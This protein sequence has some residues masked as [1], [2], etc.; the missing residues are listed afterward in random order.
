MRYW[1]LR[2]TYNRCMDLYRARKRSRSI[3][4]DLETLPSESAEVAARG[5]SLEQELL[6]NERAALLRDCIDRL[7]PRLRSVM[8]LHL[9][10]E[11]QYPEIAAALEITE[12][13]VRKRMQQA[14]A[15]LREG[16]GEYLAGGASPRSP[17]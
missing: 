12:V 5:A 15:L 16:L 3:V 2:L 4:E 13:N 8:E 7:P 9:G 17:R 6:D 11:M 10:A 14:R 1:L